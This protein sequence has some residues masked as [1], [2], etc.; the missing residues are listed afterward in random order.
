MD[1]NI[2]IQ[3]TIS[4]G[5]EIPPETFINEKTINVQ[6]LIIESSSTNNGTICIPDNV[7]NNIVV[8]S[9]KKKIFIVH[10]HDNEVKLEVARFIEKIGLEPI[11][12]H[13]QVNSGMTV[14]EKI[15]KYSDV[16]F[17]I[18]LYTPC[19]LGYVKG[20]KKEKKARARQNV[21]FEHGYLIGKLGRNN[22]CALVKGAIYQYQYAT[23]KKFKKAKS[24]RS[25]YSTATTMNRLAK[26][27]KYYVRV[28][29]YVTN[30]GKNYYGAWSKV[31]TIHTENKK[32]RAVHEYVSCPFRK[33][34]EF[35]CRTVCRNPG[36][37]HRSFS[38]SNHLAAD[39]GFHQSAG[40]APVRVHAGSESD[41][42]HPG[43]LQDAECC[44]RSVEPSA[45][46]PY[47]RAYRQAGRRLTECRLHSKAHR[48]QPVARC[49][50]CGRY[51]KGQIPVLPILL[52]LSFS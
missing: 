34:Q 35:I 6:N 33:M 27:K 11:I 25:S 46:P 47:L 41:R 48:M 22:V 51:N 12:L 3:N 19:D 39:E 26:K 15:E 40:S 30:N 37:T 20:K 44:H 24:I 43:L 21:V 10:G 17:G 5:I 28:R 18:V 52:R 29:G 32:R 9:K 7:S 1:N 49:Q 4:I 8:P 50:S 36:C 42:R 13:E 23:S 31:K 2:T 16:E 14:I 45:L 38:C